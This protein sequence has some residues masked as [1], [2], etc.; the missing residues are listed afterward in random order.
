MSEE[1]KYKQE[2]NTDTYRKKIMTDILFK[3]NDY[4][5]NL[6]DEIVHFVYKE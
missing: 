2:R 1:V 6:P 5:R 3:T 4:I